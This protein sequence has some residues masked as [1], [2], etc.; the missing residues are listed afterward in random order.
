LAEEIAHHATLGGERERAASAC[1]VAGQ[2][3][4]RLFAHEEAIEFAEN[5]LRQVE[6]LDAERRL[7]TEVELYQLIV[8]ASLGRRDRA[9][10]HRTL[11]RLADEAHAAGQDAPA[12]TA[13]YL[14][15]ILAEEAGDFEGAEVHTLKAVEV[16]R[17]ADLATEVRA[18]AN[19]GRCLAQL[20]RELPRARSLLL[21]ARAAAGDREAEL[22]DVPW[23]LG[24]VHHHAGE[25]DA[26]R[27]ELGRALQRARRE[28]DH[29]PAFECLALLAVIDLDAGDPSAARERCHELR[30]R[31]AKLGEGSEGPWADALEA[32]ARRRRSETEA[33]ARLEAAI[34]ALRE[35]D[36]KARLATALNLAAADDF[37]RGDTQTAE[38]RANEAREAAR[39][40]GRQG[41]VARADALLDRIGRRR[42]AGAEENTESRKDDE[43]E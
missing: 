8:H 30:R 17:G 41:Q 38:R 6:P 28:Q 18:L 39:I 19:T 11:S 36:T 43:H 32:L 22:L 29:W 33:E 40:V 9:R 15:S 1:V 27:A 2:R 16:G 34:R 37:A 14:L 4:L 23:G 5:G 25:V 35:V 10:L 24:L 7:S 20:E 26:A 31:A 21:E 3:C 12:R 42:Q 13:R